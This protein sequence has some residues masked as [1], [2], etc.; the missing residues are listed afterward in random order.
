MLNAALKSNVTK[1]LGIVLILLLSP[2]GA[3]A[4]GSSVNQWSG[5]VV[6]TGNEK[7][8]SGV[9]VSRCHVLSNEHVVRGNK[10]ITITIEGYNYN[11]I[12]VSTDKVND[13]ALIKLAKCRINHYAKISKVKPVKGDMMTSIYY[14]AGF[15][16]DRIIK[17]S[18]HFVGYLNIITE[19]RKEMQSM[20]I[21]DAQPKRGA[22]GGG[23]ST[24]HGL[25]SVIFG[26]AG[27][28]ARPQ[29]FAVNY[30]SLTRFLSRNN[31]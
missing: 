31:I 11:A 28:N 26:I 10:R 22:S 3:Y 1:H 8:S 30:S 6:Y 21:D 13:L 14:K 7:V 12:V 17:T 19:E 29:T 24:K 18:G 23:V 16:T 9:P 20:V 15:L 4:A 25:V 27:R 2:L 5:A